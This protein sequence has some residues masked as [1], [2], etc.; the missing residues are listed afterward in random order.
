[1]PLAPGSCPRVSVVG[2]LSA[3]P[4][5]TPGGA[6]PSSRCG[7]TGVPTHRVRSRSAALTLLIASRLLA[8]SRAPINASSDPAVPRP[9]HP[10]ARPPLPRCPAPTAPAQ[11]SAC[12]RRS[13]HNGPPGLRRSPPRSAF[14]A[15]SL[16]AM[17]IA[18]DGSLRGAL[19][20]APSAARVDGTPVASNRLN[21][22]GLRTSINMSGLNARL[23]PTPL[24]LAHPLQRSTARL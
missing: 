13:P 14:V 7:R 24:A 16:P 17:P 19:A 5:P 15:R 10:S 9:P 3:G 1:M 11:R 21:V 22:R 6:T 12:S 23:F 20:D 2:S 4:P 8:P 18:V